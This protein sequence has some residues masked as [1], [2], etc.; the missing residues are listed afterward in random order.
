MRVSRVT[1]TVVL[2]LSLVMDPPLFLGAIQ[3][4]FVKVVSGSVW[5]ILSGTDSSWA[6]N[7]TEE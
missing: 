7:R 3:P 5:M 6:S 2:S 4:C 1:W